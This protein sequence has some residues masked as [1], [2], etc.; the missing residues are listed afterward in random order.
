ML[1]G[2]VGECNSDMTQSENIDGITYTYSYDLDDSGR[3]VKAEI[4]RDGSLEATYE[5]RYAE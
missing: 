5:I 1:L 3:V 2:L 4:R